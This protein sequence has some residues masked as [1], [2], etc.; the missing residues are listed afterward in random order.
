MGLQARMSEGDPRLYNVYRDVA[1]NFGDVMREVAARLE[2]GKWEAVK[3]YLD[4]EGVTMEQLG[5]ACKAACIFVQTATQQKDEK[6]GPALVRSGWW[7]VP[8]PANVA[9]CAIV[10][11][12]MFGYF[13]A[14]AREATIK[15]AGPCDNYQDLR[16]RGE[17]CARIMMLPW[18][19]KKW[20]RWRA[21][22][23]GVW[24]AITQ[25]QP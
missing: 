10:G 24:A 14:G 16:A 21:W 17:E 1:H 18:Y 11:T 9:L 7:N 2:D 8:E 15:G 4:K 6:M 20:L 3:Q 12:V 13:W 19:K 25:K 23:S 5:E 22:F